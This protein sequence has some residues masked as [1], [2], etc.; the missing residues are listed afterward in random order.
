MPNSAKRADNQMVK[1]VDLKRYDYFPHPSHFKKPT[2]HGKIFKSIR[3]D[4]YCQICHGINLDGMGHK[5]RDCRSCHED[6]PH[7]DQFKFCATGDSR[8]TGVGATIIKSKTTCK[9]C[10]NNLD[11]L[12]KIKLA[13]NAKIDTK[14]TAKF[15]NHT[16]K[17]TVLHGEEYFKYRNDG[18]CKTCHNSSTS[19]SLDIPTCFSCHNFPH[20]TKITKDWAVANRH[21]RAFIIEKQSKANDFKRWVTCLD[22]HNRAISSQSNLVKRSKCMIC[23]KLEIPHDQQ[24]VDSMHHDKHSKLASKFLSE[25]KICHLGKKGKQHYA[26]DEYEVLLPKQYSLVKAKNCVKCHQKSTM[27]KNKD[28]Q[29]LSNMTKMM[30]KFSKCQLCHGSSNLKLIPKKQAK[31]KAQSC[32]ICH[33]STFIRPHTTL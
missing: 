18:Y 23:H 3:S 7:S 30:N 27:I 15:H 4:N 28:L 16:F 2:D 12:Q 13:K 6:Y 22:C 10:H 5:K 21:G 1:L 29:Q 26:L 33:L 9:N 31:A 25:C 19:K 14:N 17:T 8:C 11:E 20:N 32:T 24:F